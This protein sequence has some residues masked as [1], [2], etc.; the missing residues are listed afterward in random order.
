V[1]AL[2]TTT[3]L[4]GGVSSVIGESCEAGLWGSLVRGLG[5]GLGLA[6]AGI[7]RRWIGCCCAAFGLG[8]GVSRWRL[9]R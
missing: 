5:L 4:M 2:E 3:W 8:L 6:R 7:I 9:R 1:L